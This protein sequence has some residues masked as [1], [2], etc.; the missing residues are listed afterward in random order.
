MIRQPIKFGIV[1]CGM[2][3]NIH[4]DAINHIPDAVLVGVAGADLQ[5][6]EAFAQKYQI[7]AYESYER[8]LD[9][10]MIDV[11]CICTPSGFHAQHAIMA[12][13]AGKHVALEK[14]MAF[15]TKSADEIISVCQQTGKLLTVISQLRFSEDII[16]AKKL[17][18]NNALGKLSLCSLYMKYYRSPEYYSA[19]DWKG[20][21]RFDGG[22]ALMN[23]GIH[24]VDIL[25]YIV[26]PIKDIK[27]KIGTLCHAIEV[28][29]T[30]VAM[31]EFQDGALGVIEAST[32]AYPGFD[33][34]IEIYG[35]RGCIVLRENQIEK[36]MIDGVDIEVKQVQKARTA[37]DPAALQSE[38]HQQQLKNL[39]NAITGKEALLIDCFEGRKA[40]RV[41]E[42]IYQCEND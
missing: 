19:S 36:L 6:T 40:I 15:D 8:M 4:A 5:M 27:G 34:K 32:C 39:I 7:K 41:I 28:E 23:Q 21:K 22:G 37:N 38:L 35:E 11:V 1:G 42:E 2:I 33:R 18:A 25:E 20:T 9:D 10:P 14:P 17:L 26:G 12:L 16:K 24:G 29:D 31:L 3:A 30:A 13:R